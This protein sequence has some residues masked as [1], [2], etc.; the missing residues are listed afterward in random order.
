MFCPVCKAEYRF[1]F[2]RC[3]DCD[4][5]LVANFAVPPASPEFDDSYELLWSGNDPG[6]FLEFRDAL[7]AE[8]IS[9]LEEAPG[10]RVMYRSLRPPLEIWTHRRDH[11]SVDQ[12][13]KRIYGDDPSEDDSNADVTSDKLAPADIDADSDGNQEASEKLGEGY[14]NSESA[15]PVGAAFFPEDATSEVW[16]GDDRNMAE[17]L[18]ACLR[19]NNLP[20][21]IDDSGLSQRLRVLPQA[22][23]RAEEIIRE[24]IDAKL[25]E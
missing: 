1:G 11:G 19:E 15:D 17:I 6:I 9:F 21:V 10:P 2:T 14:F 23:A 13:R 3:S 4:V 22:E 25:P 12:V 5:D 16:S 7:Q 18:Q 20:C 24:V 8:G